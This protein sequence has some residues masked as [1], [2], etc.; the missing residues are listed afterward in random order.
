MKLQKHIIQ[1]LIVL[2]SV[3]GGSCL[4]S[5]LKQAPQLLVELGQA[6]QYLTVTV[7]N[8]SQKPIELPGLSFALSKDAPGLY[9]LVDSSSGKLHGM[10]AMASPVYTGD[11]TVP[12]R[13]YLLT[14]LSIDFLRRV[15]C[16]SPG[17]YTIKATFKVKD[18]STVASS[19]I[20]IVIRQSKAN[21]KSID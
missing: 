9:L 4:G 12:S 21:N 19:P 17:T 20:S 18:Q 16:L 3:L 14:N 6:G 7:T 10:C 1:T 8:I 13:G 2:L 15:Y 11:Y 5:P